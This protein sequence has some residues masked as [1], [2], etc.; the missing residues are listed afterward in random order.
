MENKTTDTYFKYL[1]LLS[2]TYP[3]I[4][5]ACAEIIN[6]QAILNLP[7][8]TE[9]F[10]SDIHG[11]YEAFN[12]VLRNASGVIK[13]H[14]NDLYGDTIC[15]AE[16]N[17]LATLIYYPQSKLDIVKKNETN[18]SLWYKINL[19]RLIEVCRDLSSKYTRSKVR[20]ALPKEF[21]YI[22][23]ELL[24]ENKDKIN[25][26]QYYEEIIVTI[27][28]L[29]QADRF[30]IALCNLIQRFAIDKLHIIG[31]I[32]DRGPD[33]SKIMDI[34]SGYHD[35]DIQWGNHDID[36]MGAFLGSYALICNVIRIQ[37]KYANLDTIEEDY[38]INL[39]PLA[40]F[41][42]NTYADDD[43]R[44]F[45][46][47][48]ADLKGLNEK[49]SL[50]IAKM[51]KAISII[52]FKVEAQIIS[53]HP[54]YNMEYMLYLEKIN[55]EKGTIILGEKEYKLND[56]KFPTVDTN[57]PYKLSKDENDVLERLRYSFMN[58]EKLHKHMRTLFTKGSMYTI[59]NSNLLYH[60]C[61]PLNEDHSFKQIIFRGRKLSG[62]KYFDEV[63]R[64]VRE[65]YS[66]KSYHNIENSYLDFMWYLWC[67]EDS[68]LFGKSRITTFERYFLND[69]KIC[70]EPKNVYYKLRN[71]PQ[72][73][74]EILKEFGI[75]PESGHI[76]NGHVPVIAKEG[77]SPIKAG[78]K[79]YVIDGGFSKAYHDK[80]GIAGYTLIFN[81]YGLILVSHEAFQSTQQAI[82]FEKDIHSST[83]ALQY[84]N[85][86]ILVADTDIGKQLKSQI[87]DLERL[88]RAYYNGDIQEKV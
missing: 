5:S 15:E 32:Y 59:C 58:S 76:I 61:I 45:M 84:S 20:K 35:F 19:Y 40:T 33:S 22:I 39:I 66:N 78:G 27:I 2:Q 8:G 85:G 80:T 51:H 69:E 60:G 21:S 81:S 87:N 65:A 3:D 11:E 62:K 82:E 71:D 46:P 6:L 23:D 30:I 36:W 41:A 70:N 14:I 75:N 55:K 17:S 24:N 10:V 57:H 63:E 13:N 9:H 49:E 56:V 43:C 72:V 54:E 7:K 67:G 47:K 1:K 44:Q 29:H 4:N 16:K 79:L 73:C 25:K 64:A 26:K 31:D 68:P 88:L 77:E 18:M 12:H 74:G 50:N 52:Q 38:G 48:T 83:V 86:R 34:I 53:R 42:I 28:R 37:A